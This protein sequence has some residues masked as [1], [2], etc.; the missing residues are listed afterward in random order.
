MRYYNGN[1]IEN[2]D[3]ESDKIW[4][5]AKGL[6]IPVTELDQYHLKSIINC[7]KGK[8]KKTF[9]PGFRGGKKKWLK[10]LNAELDRRFMPAPTEMYPIY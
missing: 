1:N 5:T 8:G 7:W 4:A 10:I 3:W 2:K 9:P 6:C